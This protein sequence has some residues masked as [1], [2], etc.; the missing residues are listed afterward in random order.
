[1][2]QSY[3]KHTFENLINIAKIVTI[4][5]FELDKNFKYLGEKHNFWEM[6][7]ADKENVLIER[8]GESLILQPN[9]LLFHKPLE[10][11]TLASDGKRAPNV[12]VVSFECKSPAINYFKGRCIH[13][14]DSLKHHLSTVIEEARQTFDLPFFNPELKKL[15]L[16]PA[17]SLGGQQ[18]IR[19]NIEQLLIY[20]MR[21][22]P[23][24]CPQSSFSRNRTDNFSNNKIQN[25]IVGILEKN[26]Y[27]QITLPELCSQL[28]YSKTFL[29]SAFKSATNQSIMQY[30]RFL[31]IQQA[32]QLL[33]EK[34]YNI[35][36]ISQKL[37]FDSPNYFTKTFRR[38][39]GMTP[40]QYIRSINIK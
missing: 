24:L 30:Y 35:A 39:T 5:Y 33:R 3:V 22:D 2:N 38:I 7:Y 23:E 4:H 14:P 11:H 34:N 28:G 8:D 21:M 19:T 37:C 13:I 32:K 16:L 10:F 31:K 20:L 18:L 9:H 40:R 29:C 12:L 25:D 26:I 17:P 27:N 1:M 6:V 36:Q 15:E